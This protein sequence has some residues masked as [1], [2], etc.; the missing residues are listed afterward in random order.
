MPPEHERVGHPVARPSRRRR[1]GRWPG[2]TP[3]PGRR[4]AGRGRPSAISRPRP[5]PSRPVPI[6]HAVGTASSRPNAVR[7]SGDRPVRLSAPPMGLTAR[8]TPERKRP[9]NTSEGLLMPAL[10]VGATTGLAVSYHSP[11]HR[12]PLRWRL[13]RDDARGSREPPGTGKEDH[14]HGS[15]DEGLPTGG[16]PQRRPGRARRGRQDDPD[17]GAAAHLGRHRPPR[18]GR[19]RRH[20]HRLRARGAQAGPVD[21]GGAGPDRVGGPQDQPARL[22]RLRRLRRGGHGRPGGRRPGR[23]RGQR[24]RRRRGPDRC[25]CGRPRPSWGC[26]G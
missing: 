19:G 5:R 11:Y 9:S 7:W 6:A 14:C 4:R 1:R 12:R 20:G 3:W 26:P 18:P 15:R 8:S 17:R 13:L 22:P 10:A 21:L 2:P 24:R 23:V 25:T 16:D